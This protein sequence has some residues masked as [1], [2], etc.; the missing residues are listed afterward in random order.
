M[1][2]IQLMPPLPNPVFFLQHLLYDGP[3]GALRRGEPVQPGPGEGRHNRRFCRHRGALLH[4]RQRRALLLLLL[5]RRQQVRRRHRVRA[6]PRRE[7]PR[8]GDQRQEGRPGHGRR[9][10]VVHLVQPYI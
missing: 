6:D 2:S 4:P 7:S 1:T 5:L 10:R 3:H 9:H 8:S